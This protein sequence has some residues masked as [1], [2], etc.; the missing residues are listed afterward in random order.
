MSQGDFQGYY[1]LVLFVIFIGIFYWA[2]KRSNKKKFDN[3]AK[4]ILKDKDS[5]QDR[6]K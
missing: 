5:K 1:T 4:S 6:S 3:I 2:Y